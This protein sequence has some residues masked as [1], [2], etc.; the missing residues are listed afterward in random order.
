MSCARPCSLAPEPPRETP[1]VKLAASEY[2]A[3]RQYQEGRITAAGL[4]DQLDV[5]KA[6]SRDVDSEPK[7]PA[8]LPSNEQLQQWAK[9]ISAK[10]PRFLADAPFE[11]R[12][13]VLRR[14]ADQILVF[15]DRLIIRGRIGSDDRRDH[16]S[17]FN[18]DQSAPEAYLS[19][20]SPHLRECRRKSET[21]LSVE[22][23]HLREC[24]R[25]PEHTFTVEVPFG[26]GEIKRNRKRKG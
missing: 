26:Y 25:S 1:E 23:P 12:R 4:A 6:A 20:A 17:F 9:T 8:K 11:L 21:D 18:E 13:E 16:S 24:R 22:S 7:I 5:L 19:S 3:F 14:L 10:L 2:Q 15:S